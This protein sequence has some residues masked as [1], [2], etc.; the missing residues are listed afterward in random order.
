M[1]YYAVTTFEVIASKQIKFGKFFD[2]Y[3]LR[4]SSNDTKEVGVFGNK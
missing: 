3:H 1:D 4:N 2:G